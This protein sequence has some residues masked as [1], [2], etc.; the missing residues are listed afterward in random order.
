MDLGHLLNAAAV[1]WI[2]VFA[3]WATVSGSIQLGGEH[4]NSENVKKRLRELSDQLPHLIIVPGQPMAQEPAR[5]VDTWLESLETLDLS[6]IDLG[7]PMIRV[8]KFKWTTL[9]FQVG[10]PVLLLAA[11][12]MAGFD[13]KDLLPEVRSGVSLLCG[14]A[15]FGSLL[16]CIITGYTLVVLPEARSGLKRLTGPRKWAGTPDD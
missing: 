5:I 12:L 2:G 14:F 6:I 3:F 4:F 11:F 1:V 8:W 9:G 13:A 10:L 16:I 7:G 15:L